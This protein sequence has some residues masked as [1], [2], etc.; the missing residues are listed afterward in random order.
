MN[1]V[2]SIRGEYLRYKNLA[3]SA[4]RQAPDERLSPG[5]SA[6][7]NSIAVICWHVSGN[8]KSRFTDFLTTDGEKP[9]RN[10]DEEFDRRP[11]SRAELLAKWEDGW[12]TLL[13]AL[14]E[15]SDDDLDRR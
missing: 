7:S 14:S 2:E 1:V 9:W 5:P 15:L 13:A 10:R 3:E 6:D 12:T 4:I 11:V 8:L